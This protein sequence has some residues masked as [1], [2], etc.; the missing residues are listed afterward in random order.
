LPFDSIVS[1]SFVCVCVYRS[2]LPLV[3]H[4]VLAIGWKSCPPLPLC[5][6]SIYMEKKRGKSW[7]M[8]TRTLCWKINTI[9]IYNLYSL[10]F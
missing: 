8:F 6:G 4:L 1:I 5:N 9:Y 7:L 2:R 3:S 10:S